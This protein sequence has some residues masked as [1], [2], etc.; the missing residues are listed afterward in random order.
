MISRLRAR[1]QSAAEAAS[2]LQ[3]MLQDGKMSIPLSLQAIQ[4]T[5]VKMGHE[6]GN[7]TA[8]TTADFAKSI[9]PLL[10]SMQDTIRS[11]NNLTQ[12]T[13]DNSWTT[14][15]A[16]SFDFS[17]PTGFEDVAALENS[18]TTCRVEEGMQKTA[19]DACRIVQG[20]KESTLSD[21]KKDFHGDDQGGIKGKN[22]LPEINACDFEQVGAT[23][24]SPKEYLEYFENHFGNLLSDWRSSRDAVVNAQNATN[25]Q[26]TL[27]DSKEANYTNQKGDCGQFQKAL[28]NA[29][30][31]I[32]THNTACRSY[33]GC[34]NRELHAYGEAQKLTKNQEA[35]QQAE[36]MGTLKILCMIRAFGKPDLNQ[37]IDVCLA[38]DYS[39]TTEVDAL[40][41]SYYPNSQPVDQRPKCAS[42]FRASM[43]PG[44]G[45]FEN[46]HYGSLPSNA[47]YNTCSASC[48]GYAEPTCVNYG[49]SSGYVKT[50]LCQCNSGCEKHGD[51]CW[52]YYDHCNVST[53]EFTVMLNEVAFNGQPATCEGSDWIELYNAGF[54]RKDVKGWSLAVE[55]P[56][57]TNPGSTVQYDVTFDTSQ[58]V[59][60]GSVL[61]VCAKPG[62]LSD[63]SL[64]NIE[65]EF[66]PGNKITWSDKAGNII[67]STTVGGHTGTT[68]TWSRLHDGSFALRD[69]TPGA[70]N[71]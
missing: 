21:A 29:A 12:Q 42:T 18:H 34:Y 36:M 64:P 10:F 62:G 40:K 69:P 56:D 26:T 5:L 45:S 19:L 43:I 39:T 32:L 22:A 68:K 67:A 30:C 47:P 15:T 41:I 58:T 37:K 3:H 33:T 48:C 38:T 9:E 50:Q 31:D 23:W 24:T 11:Q 49:C 27:C 17:G 46:S 60:P 65:V 59:E 63:T 28:E 53:V 6:V 44:T 54:T 7:D 25:L 8:V 20:N 1:S 55:K 4:T 14:F 71:Q 61:L 66:E 51:C 52:D 2:E 57:D 70:K 13:L 16:C 35:E